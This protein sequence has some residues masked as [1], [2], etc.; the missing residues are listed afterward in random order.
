MG[1]R[2]NTCESPVLAATASPINV[3][4]FNSFVNTKSTPF[5]RL[6]DWF[7]GKICRE[8]LAGFDAGVRDF[9]RCDLLDRAD[10]YPCLVS[11][12]GPISPALCKRLDDEV[13]NFGIHVASCSLDYYTPI[14]EKHSTKNIRKSVD[15]PKS[16][17]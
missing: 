1:W 3:P 17:E 7:L 16:G 11:D 14:R 9:L 5:F 4:L 15:A 10:R 13:V 12:L 2:K 8:N 6:K